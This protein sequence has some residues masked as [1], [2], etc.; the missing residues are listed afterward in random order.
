MKY[1][2][3]YVKRLEAL[4]PLA[5]ALR[6]LQDKVAMNLPRDF[7]RWQNSVF[8]AKVRA[9]EVDGQ[10]RFVTRLF[11]L[12]MDFDVNTT[13][14]KIGFDTPCRIMRDVSEG[15]LGLAPI[16]ALLK[17]REEHQ[18]EIS[19]WLKTNTGDGYISNED[20]VNWLG[21]GGPSRAF[22]EAQECKKAEE[23]IKQKHEAWLQKMGGK[24]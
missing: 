7:E 5:E 4:A 17:Y 20:Y 21:N 10:F 13:L 14:A 6:F 19:T 9:I 16:S 1:I 22:K 12:V 2:G 11:S 15:K 8:G 23:L 18:D 24:R 3:P